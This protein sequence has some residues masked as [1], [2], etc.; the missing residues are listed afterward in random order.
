GAASGRPVADGLRR[1][2]G[3]VL[4]AAAA[5]AGLAGGVGGVPVPAVPPAARADHLR[6][7]A[8]AGPGGREVVRA[9]F[10]TGLRPADGPGAG[11]DA[12][13]GPGRPAGAG[14]DHRHRVHL[15]ADLL[16]T[17]MDPLAQSA[18]A[19]AGGAA[20]RRLAARRRPGP[21]DLLHLPAPRPAE[22]GPD[23]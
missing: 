8:A 23:D 19:A 17:A 21:G 22:R 7:P 2:P 14:G 15:G 18:A 3:G 6:H 9:G 5:A 1:G 13:A 10:S 4:R 12:P 11:A 20:P 16:L